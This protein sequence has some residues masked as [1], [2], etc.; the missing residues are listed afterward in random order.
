[1]KIKRIETNFKQKKYYAVTESLE[2]EEDIAGLENEMI[3]VYPEIEYQEILGFGGAFTEAAAYSLEQTN[4]KTY[5]DIMNDYFSEQGLNYTFCRT[6]INSCDFSLNSYSYLENKDLTQFSIKRD[7]R[8]LIPMIQSAL[9]IQPN[10]KILASPWSPPAFCKTNHDMCQGGKLKAEYYQFWAN[11]LVYYIKAYQKENI[12]IEF[13]TVQNEPKAT[14][15]WESCLYSAEEEKDLLHHY[16]YPTLRLNQLD[17][18]LLIWDH[19]KERVLE[20]A[21][22][23][24]QEDTKNEIDGVAFHWYSGDYF[25]NIELVRSQYPNLLLIHTEGCT[26]YSHFNPN[27]EIQNGEIYA[28]DIIGDLNH[29]V[30]AFIDWNLV[31]NYQGG[32]NHKNNFCNSPIMLNKNNTNYIKN[33]TYYYIGHFSKYIKPGAKRIA[34]CK[35]TDKLEIT[36]FKNK[37]GHVI[38]I[39]LNKTEQTIHY[40]L[41]MRNQICDDQIASHSIITYQII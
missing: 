25:E 39:V 24:I 3:L 21:N 2:F 9:K 12:P 18:K 16:L 4:S 19:N 20:R 32:P 13:M 1:M 29:G 17:T 5:Q 37:N 36:A 15:F 35:Y 40:A 27:E 38:I 30:N 28:H 22:L 23:E 10:L 6:H 26:G 8:Y 14:Q 31:L 7:Q 33:L 41:R 11:Y 34:T